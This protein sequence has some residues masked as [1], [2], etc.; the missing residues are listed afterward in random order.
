MQKSAAAHLA[1]ALLVGVLLASAS[2]LHST[3]KMRLDGGAAHAAAARGDDASSDTGGCV[4]MPNTQP[5]SYNM[6]LPRDL[7]W[8][9]DQPYVTYAAWGYVSTADRSHEF[10]IVLMTFAGSA[11]LVCPS[12]SV[13]TSVALADVANN[14]FLQDFRVGPLTTTTLDPYSLVTTA[15]PAGG[16]AWG[17]W[18]IGD[19]WRVQRF[20]TNTSDFIV[21]VTIDMRTLPGMQGMS[22][23]G[24][25]IYGGPCII[26]QLEQPRIGV[27]GTVYIARDNTTYDVSGTMYYE[28]MFG[29][30]APP[31]L[32]HVWVYLVSVPV[33]L[34]AL[35]P[36]FLPSRLPSSLSPPELFSEECDVPCLQE[37]SDGWSG[38]FMR[39]SPPFTPPD[40]SFGNLISPD[41]KTNILVLAD[42]Y[43][44]TTYDPVVSPTNRTW[45]T[46]ARLTSPKLQLDVVYSPLVDNNEIFTGP[47]A[48]VEAMCV[49]KGTHLGAAVTGVGFLEIIPFGGG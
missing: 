14:A 48:L 13:A 43:S 36:S 35:L 37:L 10:G 45:N 27:A 18:Q 26:A 3:Q 19:D 12:V 44:V 39:W 6:S 11:D 40:E 15:G 20:V 31:D 16:P 49:I 5:P 32:G 21:D 38:S 4:C 33:F 42:E 2:A 9:P 8:H 22:S 24:A 28:L 34:P 41:G 17:Q 1:P 25:V 7:A 30:V 23:H 29:D 47:R 46:T